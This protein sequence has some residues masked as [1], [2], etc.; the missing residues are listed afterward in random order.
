M[1]IGKS[2]LKNLRKALENLLDFIERMEPDELPYF[3]RYFNTMK[4]NIDIF[5]H[6]RCDDIQDFFPVLERDWAASHMM[7]IGVQY[8]DP[9]EHHPGLDPE[10]C[11]HFA[12]LVAEVGKYFE[13]GRPEFVAGESMGY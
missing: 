13:R 12:R 4:M 2:E 11:L 7:F 6:M 9:R 1:R 10:V 8:Y 3:H 5:F